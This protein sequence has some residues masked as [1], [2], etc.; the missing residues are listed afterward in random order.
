M[1]A[2]VTGIADQIKSSEDR[3]KKTEVQMKTVAN[4][5]GTI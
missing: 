3:F 1:A 4:E 2:K 5:I